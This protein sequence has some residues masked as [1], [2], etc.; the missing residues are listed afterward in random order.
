MKLVD[1]FS[2]DPYVLDFVSFE[3]YEPDRAKVHLIENLSPSIIK[4]EPY[5][6]DERYLSEYYRISQV[7]LSFGSFG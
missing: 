6:F 1:V 2:N 3:G 7:F 5:A 4:D